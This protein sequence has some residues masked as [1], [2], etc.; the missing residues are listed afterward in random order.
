MSSFPTRAVA[1]GSRA[2]VGLLLLITSGHVAAQA[3]GTV[4]LTGTVRDFRRAHVD[5]DVDP[6]DGTGHYAGNV[7][8]LVDPSGR[9]VFT[10]NGFLVGDQWLNAASEPIPPHLYLDTI[11]SDSVQ[12]ANAPA[13]GTGAVFD[14][15]DS[16]V[17]PYGGA[18]VGPAPVVT[19]GG[20]MPD[21][22]YPT[23]L[24]PSV[25]DVTLDDGPLSGTLHCD[26]LTISGRVVLSGAV[27]ILCEQDFEMATHS[28]VELLP[29][30]TVALY[31]KGA[32]TFQPLTN[33]NVNTG[34]PRLATIYVLGT[35]ELRIG[36]P[37][38]MVY[39]TVVA[40]LAHMIVMPNASFFGT[41]LGK[42]LTLMD[43][44]GFHADGASGLARDVCGTVVNDRA[45]FSAVN[46]PGAIA[47][48]GSFNQWYRDVLGANLAAP[49]SI[50]LFEDGAG[51]YE[52]RDD[53]FYPID[54]LLFGNEGDAH[55]Y[56]F[57]YAITAYFD[58]HACTGQFIDFM[59]ADDAWM[60]V[61]DALAMD[62]GGLVPDTHQLVELDRMDLEDGLTY[63]MRFFFAH[64]YPAPPAFHLRTNVELWSD[65]PV[66]VANFPCD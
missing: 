14:T 66:V 37:H 46:S 55:N 16:S 5:F 39:A 19:V 53:T 1:G 44:A 3:P 43:N 56:F 48:A 38:G 36:Q 35:E 15:W 21:L 54:G 2:L 13:V 33:F 52:Y 59:G 26:N 32:V 8:L 41:Y 40:P 28:D 17:G 45:G 34:Q 61:D 50:T 65:A 29:G 9:P 10:G 25:G 23:W 6:I 42:S 51:V 24:G 60:F 64:R 22:G 49:H 7:D 58:Y 31:V 11:G 62:L 57:T 27:T 12:V 20:P 30:A 4:T 63:E 47:S 18:N